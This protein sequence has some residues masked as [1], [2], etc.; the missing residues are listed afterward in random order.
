[1]LLRHILSKLTDAFP[2]ANLTRIEVMGIKLLLSLIVVFGSLTNAFADPT[3]KGCAAKK[4]S[5][6]SELENA[7]QYNNIYKVKRLEKALKE[8]IAHCDDAKLNAERQQKIAEKTRKVSER[9][10]ELNAVKENGDQK[11][12]AKKTEKLEKAKQELKEA[13][14]Q[15]NR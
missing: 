15:L 6:E 13:K 9:E 3:L 10:A 5:I 8:N 2:E 14:E 4:H 12:I 11:K 1:M 7:R